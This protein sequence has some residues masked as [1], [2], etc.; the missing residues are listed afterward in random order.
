MKLLALLST[1]SLGVGLAG[2]GGGSAGTSSTSHTTTVAEP[3]LRVSRALGPIDAD[4]YAVLDFGHPASATERRK[5]LALVRRYYAV[6]VA[7]DGPKACSMLYPSAAKE[8]VEED[9]RLPGLTGSTCAVVISKLFKQR[10][11]QIV[12]DLHSFKAVRVRIEGFDGYVVLRFAR[13]IAARELDLHLVGRAWRV[14][15]AL[16]IPMR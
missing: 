14:Q 5:I 7:E 10:H 9:G 3:I 4:D 8:V 1:V 12:A 6:A 2:C 16:D 11:R 13:A 15:R